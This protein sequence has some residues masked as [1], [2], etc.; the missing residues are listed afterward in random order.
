[1]K[2]LFTAMEI[3]SRSLNYKY[4]SGDDFIDKTKTSDIISIV[5]VST[6]KTS[7]YDMSGLSEEE[8]SHFVES[9]CVDYTGFWGRK[10]ECIKRAGNI[11]FVY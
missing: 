9:V 3:E 1:M 11:Y 7:Y 6:L 10:V 8:K 2:K 4:K 5:S